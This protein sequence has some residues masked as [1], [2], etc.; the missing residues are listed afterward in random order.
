LE[1]KAHLSETLAQIE[2]VWEKHFSD[3]VYEFQFLDN[4]I[5][6]FYKTETR[7]YTLFKIFAGLAILISCLGLWGLVTFVSQQRTKEI[8]IRK[9]LG[10]SVNAILWLLSKDF[11]LMILLAFAIASPVT[12]Y[13]INDWLLNFAFRIDIGWETFVMTG[14]F[15]LTVASLTISVQTIKASVT[16]PVDSL[17][18]E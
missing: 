15:L 8:G 3:Q 16:N 18:S 12:Y 11:L 5:D 9:V 1:S 4:Q 10:A 2:Y 14:V 7:L 17:R 6:S 13:F